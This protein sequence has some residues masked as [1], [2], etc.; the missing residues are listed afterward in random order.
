VKGRYNVQAFVLTL[1]IIACL[2]LITVVLL[3]SGK[4][5]MGVIFGGGS[6]SVFGSGGAGGLL[7]KLTAMFAA[8][9]LVTSLLYNVLS[10]SSVESG[11]R[12]LDIEVQEQAPAID[13][14]EDGGGIIPV[15]GLESET[16]P[17]DVFKEEE[18]P[19]ATQ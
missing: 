12:I 3:Q 6:S 8:I 17:G 9:F 16:N 19:A 10:S 18:A 4:E 13:L 5:G 7:T 1:H 2:F 14:P 11:S 15:P